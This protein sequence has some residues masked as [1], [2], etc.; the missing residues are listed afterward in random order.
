[1]SLKDDVVADIEIFLE[2][3]EF[4]EELVI[5]GVK[6]I[7]VISTYTQEKSARMAETFDGLHGDWQEIYFRTEDFCAVKKFLPKNGDWAII[8]GK[9]Y[10]VITSMDQSGIA[11]IICA[12]YRQN[13]LR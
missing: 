12:A 11:K 8:N 10:D 9:R 5:D 7:G 13:S 2:L 4:G 6:L 3:E 1:M